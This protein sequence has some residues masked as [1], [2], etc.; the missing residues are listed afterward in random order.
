MPDLSYSVIEAPQVAPPRVS[1]LASAQEVSDNSRW[2][3]G[4]TFEPIGCGPFGGYNP[5][6]VDGD[7]PSYLAQKNAPE[8]SV[9]PAIVE[10]E[11]YGL[12]FADV[13][14]TATFM[15]RDFVG[16]AMARYMA[17]ESAY[18]A[19]ELWG[20]SVATGAGL[21]NFFLQNGDAVDAGD[22]GVWP[23][24]Q[25]LGRLQQEV[26]ATGGYYGRYMIHAPRDVASLWY[27]AGLIR[28]EGTVLLDAYDNIVVADAGYTGDGPDGETRTASTAWVYA[29]DPIQ[30][31]RESEVK[32][33]PD[34]NEVMSGAA[35]D[36]NVNLIEWRVERMVA[37]YPS[38]CLHMSI[39]TD[40]CATECPEIPAS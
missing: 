3:S 22:G 18:M 20:G 1:L 14:S 29:T 30:V 10:Y 4:I 17:N 37:A 25:A 32:L 7:T 31:R 21:P 34:R 28:R 40:V 19:A 5:L 39:E 23:A 15:S 36:R 35:L 12:W 27:A 6:C 16:R 11:P 9:Q 24:V 2:L 33:L 26:G 8:E 13:C 38:G